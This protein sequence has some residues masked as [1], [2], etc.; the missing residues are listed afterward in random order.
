MKKNVGFISTRFSGTD[1]VSLEAS[2]W[3]RIFEQDG[4]ACFWFGGELDRA[5]HVCLH[6]PQAHFKDKTNLAICEHVFGR[7][8]RDP[9]I[10]ETIHHMR[11]FL[12]SRL[13]E[14]VQKFKIELLVVE[15]ALSIP[16]HIPLG[17]ALTE[18]IAESQISTICHHHDF[19]WERDRFTLNAVNDY[20]RMSFPPILPNV[21]HV[22]INSK[23]SEEISL[24]S[25]ISSDIIPNVMDFS[26]PP[27]INEKRCERFRNHLGLTKDD[28]VILQPTR[29]VQRKGIEQAVELVKG[30]NDKRC[31]LIVSHEAGDEGF[32]YVNWLRHFARDS[33]VDLRIVE[34]RITDPLNDP[35]ASNG[36]FSL[37][38]IYP[39]ADFVTYPSL[40]EGF[41][42][43][44]VEAVY[45]KKPVLINR[46]S[47]FIKDIEP[48][49]FD[50]VVMD[51]YLKKQTIEQVKKILNSKKR[52]N[53]MVEHNFQIAAKSYSYAVLRRKLN[54]IL[55]DFFGEY[56]HKLH[57]SGTH[58]D[59]V[60]Y[61][62]VETCPKKIT[63]RRTGASHRYNLLS[64]T[65][66]VLN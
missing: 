35:E 61:L 52:R 20:L 62:H 1:G 41:G 34:A 39:N 5:P 19:Y 56:T 8:S 3:A 12:K 57:S 40:S 25:G 45:F 58:L 60:V 46:Y 32:E 37:W 7:T 59:N 66:E 55:V 30:M 14:F 26:R 28:I 54:P 16:M 13:Y 51:G 31:K 27:Q 38:D 63:D 6:V 33:H 21:R 23:A 44:F 42:N 18:F 22:V 15:N 64:D 29:I 47:T 65:N 11:A 50:L 48:C 17:L 9:H 49:G 43:A 2:K 4:Y 36:H 10:T 53:D 24:R